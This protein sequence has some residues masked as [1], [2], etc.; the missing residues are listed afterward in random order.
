MD[1]IRAL[2]DPPEF[3]LVRLVILLFTYN[4]AVDA[5]Y[6]VGNSRA[7]GVVFIRWALMTMPKDLGLVRIF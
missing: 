6:L 4:P 1:G 5:T 2:P 3:F 7:L